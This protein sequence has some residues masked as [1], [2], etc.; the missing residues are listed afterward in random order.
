MPEQDEAV[1]FAQALAR[2]D[3]TEAARLAGSIS[4]GIE[5]VDGAPGVGDVDGSRVLPA[6]VTFESWQR[7]RSPHEIKLLAPAVFA[8]V[9]ANLRVDAVLFEPSLD[10]A[11]QVPAA[12]VL[13]LLRG[14]APGEDGAPRV[15][16]GVRLLPFPAL[17]AGV[18]EALGADRADDAPP[19]WALCRVTP[20]GSVPVLAVDP[21]T[22]DAQ[23][24]A[25]VE[26]LGRHDLPSDLEVVRLGEADAAFVASQWSAV[27]L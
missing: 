19:A 7:F 8:T 21:R 9:L 17:H 27:Q 24:A 2:R 18:S 12:D 11:T 10:T 22:D 15:M 1:A 26:R 3:V 14:E 20:G 16:G 4:Y 5:V 23:I 13:G 25:L 6:F